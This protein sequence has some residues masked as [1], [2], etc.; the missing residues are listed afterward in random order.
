MTELGVYTPNGSVPSELAGL[1][2]WAA[3]LASARV[4]PLAEWGSRVSG[5]PVTITELPVM[6]NLVLYAGDDFAMQVEVFDA[7]GDPADLTGA[8]AEAQIRLAPDSPN[9]AGV[10]T[11]LVQ[12]A[13]G[14]VV[15]DLAGDV[16][17]GLGRI[18]AYDCEIRLGGRTTTLIA[19]T[20]TMTP[21]ITRPS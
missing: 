11:P 2:R 15:L 6:V 13:A 10:F 20:I 19:G 3:A 7:A 17:A 16:S 21:Q 12:E 5:E 1:A 8:V 4:S 9:V 18:S 14:I